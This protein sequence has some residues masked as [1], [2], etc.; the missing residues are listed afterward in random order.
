MKPRVPKPRIGLTCSTEDAGNGTVPRRTGTNF[1]YVQ[2]VERMGGVPLLL[3]S[4][5]PAIADDLL[6]GLSGLLLTGGRDVHPSLYGKEPERRLGAVDVP[7]DRLEIPLIRAALKREL[8]VFAICRGL[9]VLNVAAGGT[10]RQDLVTDPE[11]FVQHQMET[12]GGSIPH[13]SITIEPGTLLHRLIGQPTVRVNSHHHQAVDSLAPG[14]VATAH[15]QD[16]TIEALEDPR[17]RFVLGVQWHPEEMAA[18]DEVTGPLFEGFL[19]ACASP[20]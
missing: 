4:A 1:T 10:L 11:A 12:A 7:R 8:P 16:D 5:S 2:W 3:P 18:G 19:A 15:A 14:L 9:Q 20:R 13:H 17:A 6:D